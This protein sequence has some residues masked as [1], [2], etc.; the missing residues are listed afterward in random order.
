MPCRSS[1]LL[2]G[3]DIGTS[4]VKALAF[5][6]TGSCVAEGR[7]S[8]ATVYSGSARAE[9]HPNDWWQASVQALRAMTERLNLQTQQVAG[10]GLTGQCPTFTLLDLTSGDV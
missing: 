10:I 4:S 1:M 9:Q 6:L 2:V 3:L 7:A 5:T 8:F